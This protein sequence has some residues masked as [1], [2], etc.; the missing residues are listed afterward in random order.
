VFEGPPLSSRQAIR[1]PEAPAA[2]VQ[3]SFAVTRLRLTDYRS[4][5]SLAVDAAPGVVVVCGPNG[6]GK[7]NL[8]E[9]LS[10]LAPGRG[11]RRAKLSDLARH[12]AGSGANW[13]VAARATAPAGPVEI[14]TGSDPA[15]AADAEAPARRLVR[16]DGATA[17]PQALAGA[18]SVMWLTPEMDRLFIEGASGRRRFFDRLVYGFVPDHAARVSAYEK[19]MRERARL[20]R[21]GRGDAAWLAALESAMAEHGVAVAAARRD[22]AARLDRASDLAVG[23]FPVPA[24]AVEGM[25]EDALADGPALAAEDLLRERL[26]ASRALDAES[27]GAAQGPHR[28][29]LAVRHAAKDMPAALCSTGEQKALLVA[30]VLAAAR[31]HGIERGA[32]PMLLLDEIAAHLDED[33]RAAL[34]DEICALGGQAWLS[35]ADPELFEA[36]RGRAAFWRIADGTV[37][38]EADA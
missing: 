17:G 6:A 2:R 22:L 34:F 16:I 28:S 31:L 14:G 19:A 29:D 7:T 25:L 33:R 24:V 18:F 21:E 37:Q 32:P 11:L 15:R 13:A 3:H 35:G 8:L 23:P 9:A 38:P 26:A 5:A 4:Y 10:L 1:A 20:L 36:L 12:G 30:L 27:G